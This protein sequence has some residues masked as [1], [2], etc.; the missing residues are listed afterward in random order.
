MVFLQILDMPVLHAISFQ[1]EQMFTNLISN[2]IKFAQPGTAPHISITATLV[3]GNAIAHVAADTSK[4]Y[5]KITIADNGIGFDPRFADKIFMVF[6]RLHTSN[7][8]GTGIGL[9]ICK[10]IVENHNGII[11]ATSNPGE[12]ATF[13]I[14]FP[15]G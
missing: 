8:E 6:Q 7:A 5:H 3:Q 1:V 11:M 9:A 15:V 12:G 2:A 4:T 10:R 13:D 14:Y